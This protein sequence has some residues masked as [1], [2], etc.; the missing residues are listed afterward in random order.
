[1]Q[2]IGKNYE[3]TRGPRWPC[4]AHLL[5]DKFESTGISVQEKKF[6]TD[7][8]QYGN[9]LGFPIR[10]IL[11]TFVLQVTLIL[12]MNFE[13][14]ALLVQEKKFKTEFQHGC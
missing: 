14:V 12:P 1:M 10:T 11:A 2:C 13:S 6:N 5:P 9:H 3:E 8:D 7:F 4:I